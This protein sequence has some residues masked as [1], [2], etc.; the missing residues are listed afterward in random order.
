MW[1]LSSAV[2]NALMAVS[3]ESAINVQGMIVGLKSAAALM[4][5]KRTSARP[6][7]FPNFGHSFIFALRPFLA[8]RGIH[9][10]R[11]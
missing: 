8:S 11:G 5:Q 1:S 3:P 4:T 7:P 9:Q 6:S 2:A 10:C